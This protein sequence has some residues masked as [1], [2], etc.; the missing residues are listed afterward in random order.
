MGETIEEL[1]LVGREVLRAIVRKEIKWECKGGSKGWNFPFLS[2]FRVGGKKI[3]S[4]SSSDLDST[5]YASEVVIIRVAYM[6]CS[7][8]ILVAPDG[9]GVLYFD[10]RH[11][12]NICLDCYY[13]T[14]HNES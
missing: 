14:K 1:K 11:G 8:R 13:N 4:T 2:V 3:L 5:M 6:S 7:D 10:P 9:M 12:Y